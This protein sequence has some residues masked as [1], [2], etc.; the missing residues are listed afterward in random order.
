MCKKIL[1]LTLLLLVPFSLYAATTGKIV[2]KVTDRETGD[3][4]QGW[5]RAQV[6]RT[7]VGRSCSASGRTPCTA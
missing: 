4:R 5:S 2:G 1:L 6:I 3:V 7:A